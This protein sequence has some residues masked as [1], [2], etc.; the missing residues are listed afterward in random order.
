MKQTYPFCYNIASDMGC[1]APAYNLA[2]MY[3]TG[4]GVPRDDR[5]AYSWARIAAEKGDPDAGEFAAE[6]NIRLK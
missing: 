3:S 4:D 5:K 2:L 6:L 1:G